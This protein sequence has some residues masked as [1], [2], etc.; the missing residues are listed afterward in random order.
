MARARPLI[1]SVIARWGT[2]FRPLKFILGH[3][4][5]LKLLA[6]SNNADFDGKDSLLYGGIWARL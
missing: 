5:A 4:K 1:A 3:E 2:Q 6:P